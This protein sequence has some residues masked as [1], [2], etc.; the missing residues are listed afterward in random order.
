MRSR[1]VASLLLGLLGACSASPRRF[2]VVD[3][4]PAPDEQ[5]VVVSDD[6]A[7]R[8]RGRVDASGA[9]AFWSV[10]GSNTR[11]PARL[12][13]DGR[14]LRVTPLS[15]VPSD[16]TQEIRIVGLVAGSIGGEVVLRFRTR[17]NPLVSQFGEGLPRWCTVDGDN[18]L[19]RCLQPDLKAD[20]GDDEVFQAAEVD[21]ATV[22]VGTDHVYDDDGLSRQFDGDFVEDR[23]VYTGLT[24]YEYG[25]RQT[26]TRIERRIDIGPDEIWGT[27]DDAL[28]ALVEQHLDGLGLVRERLDGEPGPDRLLGTPD[29]EVV[30]ELSRFEPH[31][32]GYARSE[33][34]M[35]VGDDFTYRTD[36]DFAVSYRLT[37]VD[38]LGRVVTTRLVSTGNGVAFDE[39]DV[40]ESIERW[41]YGDDGR[42]TGWVAE[43][44]ARPDLDEA[45]RFTWENN[46]LVLSEILRDPG[47]DG[48]WFTADDG[49]PSEFESIEYDAD[50]QRV[51]SIEGFAGLDGEPLTE[52]DRARFVRGFS[53]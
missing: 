13:A 35:S 50:G 51:R 20:A 3:A 36:D 9:R 1:F 52:D 49:R 44:P 30:A 21:L 18:R 26:A 27:R 4:S 34:E 24:L 45:R 53:P 43:V 10:Y 31:P 33:I 42:A 38:E 11:I 19:D 5:G 32:S 16:L 28:G 39:D 37:D 47:F 29:D 8:L 14:V 17:A 7:V 25:A 6:V 12:D 46:R 40:V 15:A 41:V 23:L 22:T 48:V 2:E